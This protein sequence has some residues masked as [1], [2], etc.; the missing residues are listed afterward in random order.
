MHWRT[1]PAQCN[2]TEQWIEPQGG[3]GWKGPSGLSHSNPVPWAGT[4]NW[5]EFGSLQ[6]V[7]CVWG[8]WGSSWISPWDWW[9]ATASISQERLRERQVLG[10]QTL[11]FQDCK[12]DNSELLLWQRLCAVPGSALR[13]EIVALVSWA[14]LHP[15][16]TPFAQ[17][18]GLLSACFVGV[19]SLAPPGLA[20]ALWCPWQFGDLGATPSPLPLWP[21][22]WSEQP[23]PALNSA[24]FPSS[25][26]LIY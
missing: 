19:P 22:G 25:C 5:A 24:A 20:V 7:C 4:W 14:Q 3:L 17:T 2:P 23:N 10:G 18:P 12:L 9:A 21:Q 11:P 15:P 1:S 16:K 26:S 8:S 13:T 6:Q